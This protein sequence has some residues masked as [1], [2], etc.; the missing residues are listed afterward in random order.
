MKM[1]IGGQWVDGAGTL[2]VRNPFDGTIVDTVP[3]G[4]RRDVDAALDSAVRGAREM[5]RL[6]GFQRYE[7]LHR[8]GDLVAQRSDELAELITREEGKILGEAKIETQRTA[9]ILYLSGE[10]AKRLGSEV[11]PLDGGPGVTNKFG[12][13]IRVP[14]GVVVA[15]T[16]FNFPLHLVS[17]KVGPALAAG[18]AVVVKPASDTPLSAVRLVEIVLEAWNQ[19]RVTFDGEF[20]QFDDVEV[21]PKPK[22]QPHPP[23]WVAT[24][25][26]D[27]I[28]WAG[29]K[30]Y[31]ILMDPH[32]S[33]AEIG[34]KRQF[35]ADTLAA[36]GHSIEGR[37][38]PMA[39]LL[40]IA[41]TDEEAKEVA[42]AGARWTVGSYAPGR[43]DDVDPVERYVNDV[44]IYGSADRVVDE[45]QRLEEEIRL[46]YI[47]CSPLSHETF[48]RFTEDVLPRVS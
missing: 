44:V 16:P 4:T 19:D 6:T 17:H 45:L 32:A 7:I 37:T 42:R 36:N 20:W 25:S 46:D 39:R 10:E 47:L 22:Q 8:A 30:G 38:L 23:F 27:A 15:V 11:V 35:F 9:E 3:R 40:A 21:L 24:T 43:D 13:T 34:R 14:V 1:H 28:E 41:E 33:H 12:F 18:N 29:S 26:E 5:A 2:E 31:S 48:M